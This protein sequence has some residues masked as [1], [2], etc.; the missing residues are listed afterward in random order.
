MG[1]LH[2][3][4]VWSAASRGYASETQ[5]GPAGSTHFHQRR[6][7]GYRSAA[8]GLR[9]CRPIPLPPYPARWSFARPPGCSGPRL[10][11]GVS[12]AGRCA[13]RAQAGR[14]QL[15]PAIPRAGKRDPPRAADLP[16]RCFG[17]GRSPS[18]V[19]ADLASPG[20]QR[21]APGYAPKGAG[22]QPQHP[23]RTP[24]QKPGDFRDEVASWRCT[25]LSRPSQASSTRSSTSSKPRSPP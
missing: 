10:G 8:A 6:M 25:Y 4:R 9:W 5:A 21:R 23:A 17:C 3:Q 19:D 7:T 15:G 12:V 20:R 13:G 11:S 24:D 16:A 18:I 2:K 14:T 22:H 1:A